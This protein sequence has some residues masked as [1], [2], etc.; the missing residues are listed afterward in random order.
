MLVKGVLEDVEFLIIS[1]TRTGKM[2]HHLDVVN[3][4]V[5]I[6]RS[7]EAPEYILCLRSACICSLRIQLCTRPIAPS[8]LTKLP[9]FCNHTQPIQN[10]SAVHSSLP[11]A[12]NRPSARPIKSSYKAHASAELNTFL[13][14]YNLS[15][16]IKLFYLVSSLSFIRAAHTVFSYLAGISCNLILTASN[17]FI[18]SSS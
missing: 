4:H 17:G 16:S 14:I 9:D 3:E 1:M 12:A 18:I 2:R 15:P 7:C 10:A 6:G 5:M 8:H 13:L 11:L